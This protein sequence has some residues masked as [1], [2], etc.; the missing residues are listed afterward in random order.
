MKITIPA[1]N[2]KANLTFNQAIN[3]IQYMENN[4]TRVIT[5][6]IKYINIIAAVPYVYIKPLKDISKIVKIYAQNVSHV[7]KGA[8][9]GEV[10]IGML[11]SINCDGVILGHSERR[12]VFG[13]TDELINKKVLICQDHDMPFILC[14]GENLEQRQKGLAYEVIKNQIDKA[15]KGFNK[16]ELMV[17]AYEPVWAI[18]TGVPMEINDIKES[19]NFIIKYLRENY[20]EV[21]VLYG[22]SVEENTAYFA[23]F[24]TGLSGVLVGSKSLDPIEFERIITL[25][26][27]GVN[28]IQFD[29]EHFSG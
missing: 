18:G 16:F 8:Y 23:T 24:N 28:N 20:K 22:G 9:T 4:L 5:D 26:F 6:N 19:A 2:W 1:A 15:L 13:E 3:W 10:T 14:V 21:P 17:L 7:L 12:N 27:S 11:K 29:K 25:T